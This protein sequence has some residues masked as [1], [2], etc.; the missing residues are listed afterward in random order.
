MLKRGVED[1]SIMTRSGSMSRCSLTSFHTE[2]ERDRPPSTLL[3]SAV[4]RY[5]IFET[6][7]QVDPPQTAAT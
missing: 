3:K 1:H 4:G 5:A 7:T 2:A 6:D